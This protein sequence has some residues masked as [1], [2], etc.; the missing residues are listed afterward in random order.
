MT[1]ANIISRSNVITEEQAR[2]AMLQFVSEHC[3]YGKLPAQEMIIKDINPSNSYHYSLESFCES[4]ATEWNF[5]PYRGQPI[6]SPVNG[7]APQPWDINVQPPE[8][9]AD[10]KTT[11]EV[12]H[13]ANIKNPC[14]RCNGSGYVQEMDETVECSICFGTG[15]KRCDVCNGGGR[16]KC[17]TC[18]GNA[19]I[20][21]F[22]E[23]TVSWENHKSDEVVG[24]AIQL[25]DELVVDSEGTELFSQ[26]LPR[27]FPITNFFE[28]QINISSKKL[29]EEHARKWPS[30]R[31]LLQRQK[32]RAVPVSEVFYEWKETSSRY[33]VF[34]LDHQVYAPDYPQKCCCGCSIL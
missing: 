1:F 26:E 3:C 13:T 16:V 34:G 8:M 19:Q 17:P 5:E 14:G 25:P 18:R 30:K 29:V 31:I 23:L 15:D 33:W 9:F 20:K 11:L 4:R 10:R 27:V 12:P 2:E 28:Q 7:V 21:T 6:D 24:Q 22:I 32:L